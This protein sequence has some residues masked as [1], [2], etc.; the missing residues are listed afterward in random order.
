MNIL[1]AYN[2]AT[3]RA[4]ARDNASHGVTCNKSWYA[5]AKKASQGRTLYFNIIVVPYER[6]KGLE[7]FGV[8]V[9]SGEAPVHG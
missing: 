6:H 5:N 3:A 7:N 2:H 4:G 9:Y 8:C 1:P